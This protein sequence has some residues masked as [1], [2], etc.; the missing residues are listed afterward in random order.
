MYFQAK[1]KK[2]LQKMAKV[3]AGPTRSEVRGLLRSL[4]REANEQMIPVS[5][6]PLW[7]D[8]IMGAFRSAS[9]SPAEAWN[10]FRVGQAYL[11]LLESSRVEKDM[12]ER[13]G[14]TPRP[15]DTRARLHRNAARVG[16]KL[17]Q[18]LDEKEKERS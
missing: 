15:D 11:T 17:P 4:L 6:N 16:L 13:Y 1:I 3:A 9:P 2:D 18:W 14:L 7:R 8:S 5:N 10:G 12:F